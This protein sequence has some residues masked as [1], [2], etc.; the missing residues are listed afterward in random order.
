MT[1]SD[2]TE[3]QPHWSVLDQ[4]GQYLYVGAGTGAST[5]RA[6]RVT[7]A[8]N[9]LGMLTFISGQ[10]FP[11]GTHAHNVTIS[12]NNQFLYVASDVSGELRAF[13]RNTADG[14]LTPQGVTA[15]GGV[16]TVAVEPQSKFVYASFLNA[17]K[18][19]SIG[20]TGALT[21]IAP[22]STFETNNTGTG[23]G[24]HSLA[25]RPGGQTLYT[26]NINSNTI[27]VFRMDAGT[28]ALS[29]IQN[30]FPATGL[31]P[32]Q[33]VVHPNGQFVF[34]TDTNNDQLSRFAVNADGTLVTPATVIPA[35]DGAQGMGITKF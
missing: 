18:V 30:P 23:S 17:V 29:I 27:T 3:N 22:P 12:P 10:S 7:Q 9:D 35:G 4:T 2:P 31:E 16:E 21:E 1:G 19:F 33:V 24:P 20:A 11:V 5:L 15:L 8:G 26:S 32:N 34:T 14:T 28:G 13:S 6:Y 25:I